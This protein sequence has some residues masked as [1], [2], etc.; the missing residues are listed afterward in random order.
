MKRVLIFIFLTPLLLVLPRIAV[1]FFWHGRVLGADFWLMSLGIFTVFGLIPAL[2][3][4]S[5]DAFIPLKQP[6]RAILVG[7]L[8]F[9]FGLLFLIGETDTDMGL[10]VVVGISAGVCSW[11]SAGKQKERAQ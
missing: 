11:L 10:P 5:V 4:S 7:A 9:G 6:L 8:G 2:I 3:L 1:D